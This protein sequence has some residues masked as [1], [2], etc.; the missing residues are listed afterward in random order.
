M[1]FFFWR[2]FEGKASKLPEALLYFLNFEGFWNINQGIRKRHFSVCFTFS[3]H[4]FYHFL[5]TKCPTITI[6]KQQRRIRKFSSR[7]QFC[8][9]PPGCRKLLLDHKVRNLEDNC[10]PKF[11]GQK[12][13][14][15]HRWRTNGQ[16]QSRNHNHHRLANKYG[17][18][19]KKSVGISFFGHF[20]PKMIK[21]LTEL[22][23]I[24]FWRENSKI[25]EKTRLAS[26]T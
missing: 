3:L 16:F 26:L 11:V 15:C 21:I 20:M 19:A 14:R 18:P 12:S 7:N 22:L 4:M 8:Q 17:K 24:S 2:S 6:R 9:I 5:T 10:K 23:T 1:I 13:F 25:F